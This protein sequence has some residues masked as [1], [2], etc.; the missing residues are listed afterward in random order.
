M[1]AQVRSILAMVTAA[2]LAV[3]GWSTTAAVRAPQATELGISGDAETL[4]FLRQARARLGSPERIAAI[5]AF[6]VEGTRVRGAGDMNRDRFDYSIL[7]PDS[8]RSMNRTVTTVMDGPRY[9]R[10]FHQPVPWWNP[11]PEEERDVRR[12][13]RLG[14]VETCLTVLLRA[15]GGAPVVASRT[16]RKTYGDVTGDAVEFTITDGGTREYLFDEKTRH[17]LGFAGRWRSAGSTGSD[18]T[19]LVVERF[20]K[21]ETV[22]GVRVPVSSHEFSPDASEASVHRATIERT[23]TIDPPLTPADFQEPEK[24]P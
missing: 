15:P 10:Q 20:T 5:N 1:T 19:F 22:S 11:T 2:A 16:G 18:A 7:F 4:A 14:F 8:Y 23:I 6:R 9:W 21:H 24:R 13:V 17:P 3:S 12:R